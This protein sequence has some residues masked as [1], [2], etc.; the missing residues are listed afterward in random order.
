MILRINKDNPEGRKIKKV[1]EV[2]ES[3]G[4]IVYPSDTVYALGCDVFNQKAVEKICRLKQLN[5]K[6]ANLS[7]V[8]EDISQI[9]E[10]ARQIDNNTFKLLK[11]NLPGPF[12]FILS[13]NNTVPKIFKNKKKTFGVRI[14]DHNIPI[15]IIKALGRPILTT[16]VKSEDD[17][18]EYYTE[19]I[20]IDEFYG[21]RVDL[22]VDGGL[23]SLDPSTIVDCTKG[24]PEIIRQS[25][26]E[27]KT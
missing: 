14:P 19:A 5:P 9:A 24:I 2:L 15:E 4:V 17:L 8:C 12:T 26:G 3:G 20:D 25:E 27:L 10:Y 18:L 16:S 22:V 23:C 11:M 6:K 21:K 13:S 1:V 7:F